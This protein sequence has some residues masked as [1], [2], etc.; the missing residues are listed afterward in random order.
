MVEEVRMTLEVMGA[1]F[2]IAQC[3]YKKIDP[4]CPVNLLFNS[5]HGESIDAI[6]FKR[7]IQNITLGKR[8]FC[9]SS[10]HKPTLEPYK[11]L[12]LF[13]EEKLSE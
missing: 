13:N 8:K 10:A 5:T 3:I 4:I 2:I 7:L 9:Q 12:L 6:L 1:L 11:L